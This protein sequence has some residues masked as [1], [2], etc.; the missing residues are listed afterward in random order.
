M[1]ARVEPFLEGDAGGLDYVAHDTQNLLC[2][3]PSWTRRADRFHMG[4]HEGLLGLVKVLGNLFM[5]HFSQVYDAVR[6]S[7]S[8]V[9]MS[10]S[11]SCKRGPT[12]FV[13][14]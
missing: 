5:K 10:L 8:Y 11:N 9:P 4:D 12:C 3:I 2:V 6:Q 13:P 14:Q 7:R 1:G